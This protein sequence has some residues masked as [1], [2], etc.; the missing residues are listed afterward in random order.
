MPYSCLYCCYKPKVVGRS[1]GKQDARNTYQ[2]YAVVTLRLVV[3]A[4]A[5]VTAQHG[6]TFVGLATE[7]PI[8]SVGV[9]AEE[10]GTQMVQ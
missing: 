7:V 10:Q 4:M 5:L 2:H 3:I 9:A 6:C 1:R 8:V